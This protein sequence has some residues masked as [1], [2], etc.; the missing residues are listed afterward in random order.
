MD[1][2]D[3]SDQPDHTQ[4]ERNK[5][6]GA[7]WEMVVET[8]IMKHVHTFEREVVDGARRYDFLIEGKGGEPLALVEVKS[9]EISDPRQLMDQIDAATNTEKNTYIIAHP[10]PEQVLEACE[11]FPEILEHAARS[12]VDLFIK[13]LSTVPIL[14]EHE[15]ERK[16][17]DHRPDAH[18]ESRK[19]AA[20]DDR[21][22]RDDREKELTEP[23]PEER[24]DAPR[25]D[26]GG[27]REPV[28]DEHD[29]SDKRGDETATR[30]PSDEGQDRPNDDR[31]DDADRTSHEH[32]DVRTENAEAESR[33]TAASS[34]HGASEAHGNDRRADEVS[35]VDAEAPVEDLAVL[36]QSHADRAPADERA[37]SE[38]GAQLEVGAEGPEMASSEA[39]FDVVKE[40]QALSDVIVEA[41]FF[42]GSDKDDDA[43]RDTA[44]RED[45]S[46]SGSGAM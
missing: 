36:A 34:S 42:Q 17:D 39:A 9:G 38:S 37:E 22:A 13:D 16:G 20:E 43:S 19:N 44:P 35:S 45:V 7:S 33:S 15:S 1:V 12:G 21:A 27:D 2:E 41:G 29:T 24:S 30:E 28:T 18:D 3:P 4:L 23:A 8:S 25:E 26:A 32:E 11:R 5:A 40:A 14:S 31:S 46:E 10:D 6:Q